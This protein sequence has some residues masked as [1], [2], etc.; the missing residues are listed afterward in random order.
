MVK[1]TEN[2]TAALKGPSGQ[3]RPTGLSP[4]CREAD[5]TYRWKRASTA[6]FS[7]VSNGRSTFGLTSYFCWTTLL[8]TEG[9]R[10]ESQSPYSRACR[11]SR[12]LS[13]LLHDA[14]PSFSAQ[15]LGATSL[16]K[17]VKN[18]EGGRV[19]G[20][21]PPH[22]ARAEWALS[23]PPSFLRAFDSMGN[24]DRWPFPVLERRSGND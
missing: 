8:Y 15:A 13:A 17:A 12:S 21:E 3:P 24:G 5:P 19:E 22:G 11:F 23:T 4:T 10:P 1:G 7:P 9:R 2:S 18:A 20:G 6:G 16:E 14:F